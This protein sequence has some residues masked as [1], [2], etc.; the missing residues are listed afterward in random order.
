MEGGRRMWHIDQIT[1]HLQ[2]KGLNHIRVRPHSLRAAYSVKAAH[3]VKAGEILH[4][5]D[6]AELNQAEQNL[7]DMVFDSEQEHREMPCFSSRTI[8]RSALLFCKVLS[9]LYFPLN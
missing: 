2:I 7:Y 4:L 1:I 3:F 8:F 9:F 6:N 5:L